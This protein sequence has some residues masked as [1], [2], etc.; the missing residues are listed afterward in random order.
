MHL[1][2]VLVGISLFIIVTNHSFSVHLSGYSVGAAVFAFA[3]TSLMTSVMTRFIGIRWLLGMY[4]VVNIPALVYL[5]HL[6]GGGGASAPPSMRSCVWRWGLRYR[7]GR[8]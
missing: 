5:S 3:C 4:A 1:P 8:C 7:R 2:V 6:S